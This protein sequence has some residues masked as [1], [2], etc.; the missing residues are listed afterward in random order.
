M[1]HHN[2]SRL[3]QVQFQDLKHHHHPRNP[4]GLPP[5]Q[6]KKVE[7]VTLTCY[8]LDEIMELVIAV[9]CCFFC[10]FSKRHKCFSLEE[11]M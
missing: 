9:P 11:A 8:K 4:P 5:L 10:S 3:S 1:R 6:F 7:N 2:V